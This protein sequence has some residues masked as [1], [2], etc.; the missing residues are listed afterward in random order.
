MPCRWVG[1]ASSTGLFAVRPDDL[2]G[3]AFGELAGRFARALPIGLFRWAD[4]TPQV[5]LAPPPDRPLA[6][7][8]AVVLVAADAAAARERGPGAAP[9]EPVD[10]GRLAPVAD[11]PR[12]LLVVGWN[13]LAAA[14][15]EEHAEAGDEISVTVL[16]GLGGKAAVSAFR[17]PPGTEIEIRSGSE[18]DPNVLREALDAARPDAVVVLST[19]L[20]PDLRTADA[21]TVVGVMQLR[22]LTTDNPVPI[23]AQVF[24]PATVPLRGR[25]D[26][27]IHVLSSLGIVARA[28]SLVVLEPLSALVIER[29]IGE[30][31]LDVTEFRPADGS[32]APFASLYQGTLRAGAVPLGFA[33]AGGRPRLNPDGDELVQPG[34]TVLVA[35]DP[36]VD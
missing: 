1:D 8:E 14:L 6:E 20:S 10:P 19:P 35:R 23:I 31:A 12:R 4:G 7:D 18:T 13:D 3:T 29:L 30:G 25:Q 2:V 21:R 15:L 34:D 28:I 16:T 24:N 22:R 32:A 17:P 26:P 5:T 36:L 33:P 27:R 9:A 11:R